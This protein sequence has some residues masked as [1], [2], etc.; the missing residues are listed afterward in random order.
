MTLLT[1]LIILT[2]STTTCAPVGADPTQTA[3]AAAADSH[4]ETNPREAIQL[5]KNIY[6]ADRVPAPLHQ[7]VGTSSGHTSSQAT[8]HAL[9][10]AYDGSPQ[11]NELA[12][13]LNQAD[14]TSSMSVVSSRSVDSLN[15]SF[16]SLF[17]EL[18][19]IKNHTAESIARLSP[20]PGP[21]TTFELAAPPDPQVVVPPRPMFTVFRATNVAPPRAD[22]ARRA[23]NWSHHSRN[24]PQISVLSG[25]AKFIN[26]KPKGPHQHSPVVGFT[27]LGN[28]LDSARLKVNRV[29]ELIGVRTPAKVATQAT[30]DNKWTRQPTR[31]KRQT[32]GACSVDRASQCRMHEQM[33]SNTLNSSFPGTFSAIEDSCKHIAYLLVN[34]WP[35]FLR[36]LNYSSRAA[37]SKK[38]LAAAS[39]YLSA[40]SSLVAGA[41]AS[42]LLNPPEAGCNV[43]PNVNEFVRDR[44]VWM[45]LNLCLD[46]KFRRSYV[47]NL[48][49]LSM[50]SH[51][52]AQ[53]VCSDEYRRMRAYVTS[54]SSSALV[55]ASNSHHKDGLKRDDRDYENAIMSLNKSRAE[56][57]Q[58]PLDRATFRPVE[59]SPVLESS[60]ERLVV[61]LD[62]TQSAMMQSSAAQRAARVQSDTE[63]HSKMHCCVFDHFIKCVNRQAHYDCGVRGAQFVVDFMSRIGTDDLKY[64]CNSQPQSNQSSPVNTLRN[65]PK[66]SVA[67]SSI[68]DT[69][70]FIESNYCNE[71]RIQY[72]IFMTFGNTPSG[73]SYGKDSNLNGAGQVRHRNQL[74]ANNFNKDPAFLGKPLSTTYSGCDTLAIGNS[75]GLLTM[76]FICSLLVI[77][78]PSTAVS[79][80]MNPCES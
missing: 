10:A 5:S 67:L 66:N 39:E 23:Q 53:E 17:D 68:I 72:A 6:V 2:I 76:T 62:A 52:R 11:R 36:Q 79:F 41:R 51:D 37:H 43:D 14:Q 64:I 30:I 77:S 32:A 40:T 20:P 3:T 54:N 45:W 50:W 12:L 7:V 28:L 69:S 13:P 26:H 22:S 71:P 1:V 57:V 21:A 31:L 59:T 19:R 70:P 73:M 34:C 24:Q 15:A 38:G 25:L 29:F 63:F 33:I 16:M 46:N 4:D 8:P 35:N 48:S 58:E 18:W 78:L 49:C 61:T 74:G 9:E 27:S 56:L 44:I 42:N 55:V 60:S 47:E 75:I 65:N 80:L